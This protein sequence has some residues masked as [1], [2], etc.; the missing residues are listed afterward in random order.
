MSS[1]RY[2]H[3]D[4][5]TEHPLEG[6]P[7]AVFTDGAGLDAGV[8]QR[9]AREMAFPESTFLLPRHDPST[10][11]RM[12]IFT[13]ARELP[14]AGHPTV[15]ST[16]ALAHLGVIK[17]GRDRFVFGLGV[18]P[19]R[20]D[21]A[22]TGDRLALATMYQQRPTFGDPIGKVDGLAAA[23]GLDAGSLLPG[24]PVQVVSCGLPFL[25]VPI[26]TATAVDSAEID[27]AKLEAVGHELGLE[28]VGFFVFSPSVADGRATAHSRMFAPEFGVVEDAATGAASGPLGCY[29]VHH[30]VVPAALAGKI[31]SN[32]GVR[33]G[34]P[35]QI[36]IAIG[37]EGEDIVEVKVGGTAVVVGEG[38]LDVD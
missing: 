23:L 21:L 3:L 30:G 35:S 2:L 37:L 27:A 36:H 28:G 14:M 18:G 19:T 29:L 15:G 25:M 22:W 4:V 5:F 11:V 26:N 12:R 34:R 32:Q 8:M 10:D 13:P 20:V 38:T 31:V 24:L 17:P 9:I 6:N 7:L 1:R 16:F 33:M